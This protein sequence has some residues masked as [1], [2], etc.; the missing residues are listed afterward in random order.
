MADAAVWE[1]NAEKSA[2]ETVGEEKAG[3]IKT[4]GLAL[5]LQ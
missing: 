3:I 4:D 2:R 5:F 1:L